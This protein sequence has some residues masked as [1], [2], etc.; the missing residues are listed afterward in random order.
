LTVFWAVAIAFT[1]AAIAALALPL[2][3]KGRRG[4]AE[5]SAFDLAVFKDQLREVETDQERGVLSETEAD[6]A[7]LEIERRML[8]AEPSD[9]AAKTGAKS[10]TADRMT[11]AALAVALPLAAFAVYF[12]LGS[13]GYDD[14]PFAARPQAPEH[15]GAP[16][17]IKNMVE[18]LAKRMEQNPNNAEGWALLARSYAVMERYEDAIAAYRRALKL[19]DN[20]EQLAIDLAETM[21]QQAEGW[22]T[23]QAQAIFKEM[24]GYNPA[25]PRAVYYLALAEAQNG[26]FRGAIQGWTDLLAW[27]P[28]DAPWRGVVEQQI[29]NAREDLGDDSIAFE[30]SEAAKTLA[31]A[32]AAAQAAT[33]VPQ[34]APQPPSQ[35]SDA[36]VSAG[37]A[38]TGEQLQQAAEGMSASERSEMIRS[39]VQRLADRLK[40]NPD[41]LEGWKRLA[42]AYDVLGDKMKAD[43][44]RARIRELSGQ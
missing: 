40:E 15:A 33:P 16:A 39:M 41:D 26:N 29:S 14:Q 36:P 34:S 4:T 38:M 43:L 27:S 11:A 23:Q 13:P 35:S 22:V 20:D 1:L 6:A 32:V 5:R 17:D 21:V 8:A 9:G 25:I 12:H 18:S 37:P 19:V 42:R 10:P 2:A 28:P 31:R 44:A 3:G 30:P 7:R 24:L